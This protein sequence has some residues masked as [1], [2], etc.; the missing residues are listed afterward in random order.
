MKRAELAGKIG[1]MV[2]GFKRRERQKFLVDFLKII[3]MEEYPNLRLTSSLAKKLI[4][5]FAGY[6]SISNGVLIKEFGRANNKVKQQNL[7]DI[8]SLMVARHRDTYKELWSAAKRKIE[9]DADK[10][11]K[12]IIEEM[13]SQ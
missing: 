7:D 5:A 1:G 2:G 6:K 8:V 9:E 3:E 10:Y 12:R 13:R 4:A 11:K